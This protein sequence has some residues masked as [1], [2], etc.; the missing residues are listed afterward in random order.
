MAFAISSA[1]W[2]AS[3]PSSLPSHVLSEI[4]QIATRVMILLD[5]KLLTVDALREGGESLR[6]GLQV[7]GPDAEV[8]AC[9][10]A[11]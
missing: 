1:R 11:V 10:V 9:L 4:P 6:L 5:G 7:A 2:P 3:K 8:R